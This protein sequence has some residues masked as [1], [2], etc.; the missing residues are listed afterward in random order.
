[1]TRLD[2]GYNRMGE[3]GSAALRKAN[4]GRSGFELRN[5]EQCASV[6]CC[7]CVPERHLIDVLAFPKFS[8]A[9][10]RA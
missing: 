6:F 7:F 9:P 3:E 8:S 2:V 10:E 1:M 5:V 4:E